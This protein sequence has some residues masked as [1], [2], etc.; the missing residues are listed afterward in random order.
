MML[1]DFIKGHMGGNTILLLYG[2]QLPE[3]RELALSVKA[4]D[5]NHLWCHECGILYPA[6]SGTDL[7]VKISEPTLPSFI[8]ACGGMTQVLGKALVETDLGDYFKIEVREPVTEVIIETDAGPTAL[9][10]HS[11]G[12]KNLCT[13]TDMGAFLEE[14]LKRGMRSWKLQGVDVNQAGVVL[15]VNA[16][17]IKEVYPRT[18]FTNWDAATRELLSGIQSEFQKKT[19]IGDYYFTLYDWHPERSGDLRIVF[20][21]CIPQDYYEPACGTG[22]IGLG[23]ALLFSGELEQRR[24]LQEGTVKLKLESGGSIELGGPDTTELILE[25]AGGELTGASFSHSLVEITVT[26][27]VHL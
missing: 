9:E 19:G 26:G 25:I 3:G 8:S 27:R 6:D 13:V 11:T 10:I 14:C 2:E 5:P 24:G 12:G 22:S 1:L 16:E 17:K 18:D 20:P 7:K 4:L 23:A 21:H 15:V